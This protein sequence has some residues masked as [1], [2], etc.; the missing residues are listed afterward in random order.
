M[1][2]G[3]LADGAMGTALLARGLP[4]GHLPEE[5]VLERPEEVAAVHH[6]HARAG[7]AVLLTCTFNAAR[8]PERGLARHADGICRSAVVLARS[9]RARLVAGCV[10]ST[11]LSSGDGPPGL[12]ERYARAFRALAAAGADLLW[13]ETHPLLSEARTALAAARR[14]G[15][16]AVATMHFREGPRGLEAV[17]GTPAEECLAALWR[18]GAHAVGAN[19]VEAGAP[20]AALVARA[21]ARVAVPIAVKPSAGLPAAPV[22]PEV[23]AARLWPALRAGARIFGGCCG[24]GPEHLRALGHAA[25]SA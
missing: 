14:T 12:A 1:S 18:D 20:L 10:G 22:P 9:A 23:F 19:C 15:L 21:A 16:P 25:R 4:A 17:D 8:L 11:G 7:A 5:W 2:P 24:T 6:A 3:L 13:T